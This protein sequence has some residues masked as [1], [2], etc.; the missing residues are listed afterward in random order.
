MLNVVPCFCLCMLCF[1]CVSDSDGFATTVSSCSHTWHVYDWKIITSSRELW[2]C[3]T[4]VFL[5]LGC[6]ESS[7]LG[8]LLLFLFCSASGLFY[9]EVISV[10][11]WI[12]Y[13]K[14]GRI[15]CG[16]YEIK[17]E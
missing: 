8:V 5:C 2:V 7:V 13:T 1:L 9:F 10:F 4:S 3:I 14:R 11:L 12:S 15:F 16:T 17:G 6:F